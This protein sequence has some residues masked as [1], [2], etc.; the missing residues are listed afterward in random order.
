MHKPRDPNLPDFF[1][2]LSRCSKNTGSVVFDGNEL[3]EDLG[4]SDLVTSELTDFRRSDSAIRLI[5]RL[6]HKYEV[7]LADTI[8]ITP[9]PE[10]VKAF[11]WVRSRSVFGEYRG[12][13]EFYYTPDSLRGLF[14]EIQDTCSPRRMLHGSIQD[15]Y[16]DRKLRE[17]AAKLQD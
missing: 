14:V 4:S 17:A 1:F 8:T 2:V 5:T 9:E 15:E 16:R 3:I 7:V 6:V 11:R 13:S 10:T 12:E